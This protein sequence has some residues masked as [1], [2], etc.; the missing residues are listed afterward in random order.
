[1]HKRQVE[2]S[3]RVRQRGGTNLYFLLP[4]FAQKQGFQKLRKN[5]CQDNSHITENHDAELR[6]GQVDHSRIELLSCRPGVLHYA[7]SSQGR[8]GRINP[9]PRHCS[10]FLTLFGKEATKTADHRMVQIEM[11]TAVEKPDF[12]LVATELIDSVIG[13]ARDSLASF[14]NVIEEH[15]QRIDEISTLVDSV[16]SNTVHCNCVRNLM[17]AR[18]RSFD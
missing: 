14:D 13:E 3:V 9:E 16:G 4:Q 11:A 10:A 7:V 18:L 17:F 1:M 8:Q 15:L 12:A 5:D 6:C 2:E